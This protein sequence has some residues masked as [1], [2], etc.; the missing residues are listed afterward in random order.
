M[1]ELKI[2]ENLTQRQYINFIRALKRLQPDE[3]ESIGELHPDVYL[4]LMSQAAIESKWTEIT[5]E[6]LDNLS[7]AE[8]AE[9]GEM[10]H[11]AYMDLRVPDPN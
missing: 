8:G 7:P 6:E 11:D 1:T 4:D 9:F 3:W 2:Q 10:V 5:M